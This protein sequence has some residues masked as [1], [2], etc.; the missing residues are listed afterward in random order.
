MGSHDIED[1]YAVRPRVV[2]TWTGSGFPN[3]ATRWVWTTTAARPEVPLG[4]LEGDTGPVAGVIAQH[5]GMQHTIA[6][7]SAIPKCASCGDSC[8]YQGM[9]P[10]LPLRAVRTSTP[11][12]WKTRPGSRLSGCRRGR[13]RTRLRINLHVMGDGRGRC[14]SGRRIL[15]K[16]LNTSY[17]PSARSCIKRQWSAVHMP[18]VWP[19]YK[20]HDLCRCTSVKQAN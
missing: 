12:R 17:P 10:A 15:S 6:E 13:M 1:S 20:L 19:P 2:F 8:H 18:M 7:R 3:T 9:Q 16:I 4:L 11:T 5:Q 14:K